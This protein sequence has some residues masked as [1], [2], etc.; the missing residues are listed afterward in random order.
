MLLPL[1]LLLMMMVYFD[2]YFAYHGQYSSIDPF[3]DDTNFDEFGKFNPD[4]FY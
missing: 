4:Y 2:E 1:P 3:D